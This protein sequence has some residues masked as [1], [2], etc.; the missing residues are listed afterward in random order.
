[1]PVPETTEEFLDIVRK[2]QLLEPAKLSA[3]LTT[4]PNGFDSPKALCKKLHVDGYIT[5]FHADQL[6]RGKYR[7][8]FLGKYKILD[9]I[10]LGGMGQVFLGEHNTM[11]R[12]VAI[13][14]LPPDRAENNF[15]RERFLREARAAGQ[16]DHPN[17]VRAFD[18]DGEG[19]VL[20]LVMEYVDGISFHDL[21][22]K[23][24]PL[25]ANRVAQ[26]LLQSAHGLSYL[27]SFGLVH[28]DIKPANLLVDRQGTVKILDLGLVRSE[29]EEDNL[30]RGEGVKMLGTADYLAP[31][32]AIDCTKVDVRADIYSLGATAYFLLTKRP[33][34][35]CEKV[36]QK[37]M[38]H[39][40]K[41]ATPLHELRPEI[42][43]NLSNIIAKMMSKKPEDRYQSPT[44]LIQIL[45]PLITGIPALPSEHEIPATVGSAAGQVGSVVLGPQRVPRDS[46]ANINIA[47]ASSTSGSAIRYHSDSKLT[48]ESVCKEVMEAITPAPVKS[49]VET[50]A[51]ERAKS[52]LPPSISASATHGKVPV[53]PSANQPKV[54]DLPDFL[55][56]SMSKP[57]MPSEASMIVPAKKR[58][59]S[60]TIALAVAFLLMLAVGVYITVTFGMNRTT[61]APLPETQKP[62]SAG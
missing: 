45:E 44:E 55:R 12:R 7:G 23:V 26:Y 25:D 41:I 46:G 18:F 8:F 30:T 38:A 16:L 51:A 56:P 2:S 27:H 19:E 24:G 54:I 4:H 21:V 49:P 14:V 20:F 9:R 11:R 36:S 43:V 29:V 58:G 34:F 48:A 22:M 59:T 57:V 10:G 37:L 42:P 13:K 62:A 3:F 47:S 15:S 33:P 31:E 40:V 61:A 6:L 17:L 50:P 35:E 5:T 1:M 53:T 32:Q 28:R 52:A 60:T 39:Q